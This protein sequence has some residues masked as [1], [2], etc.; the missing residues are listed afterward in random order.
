M[1]FQPLATRD[2]VAQ[3]L[4]VPKGTLAQWAHRGTGP[5]YIR[6]GRYAKYDWADVEAWKR[7][8]AVGGQAA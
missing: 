2:E 8:H 3:H 7:A 6:V 4:G 5:R 1:K